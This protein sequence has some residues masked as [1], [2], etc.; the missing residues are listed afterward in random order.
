[1]HLYFCAGKVLP[2]I[3]GGSAG[4]V[5]ILLVLVIVIPTVAVCTTRKK[6]KSSLKHRYIAII[7]IIVK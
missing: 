5:L 6:G 4:G 7:K 3:I 1:M 2:Y